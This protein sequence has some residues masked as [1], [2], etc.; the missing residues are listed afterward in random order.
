MTN[1]QLCAMAST[2][3]ELLTGG[4]FAA[5]VENYEGYFFALPIRA[6]DLDVS[7]GSVTVARSFV[8]ATADMTITAFALIDKN[9]ETVRERAA[10]IALTG[11]GEGAYVT[12][13]IDV[14]EET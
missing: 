12:W 1:N 8:S 4:I 7:G 10:S 9:G 13:K 14:E 11:G 2:L 5:R 3:A 6:Q